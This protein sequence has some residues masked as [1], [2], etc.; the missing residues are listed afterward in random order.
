MG[1]CTLCDLSTPQ[2]PVTDE[3]VDGEFCCRG[4]LE[5]YRTLGDVDP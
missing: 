3:D 4:C 1:A 2:Q 5:V